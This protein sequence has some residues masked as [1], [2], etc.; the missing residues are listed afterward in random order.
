M[1]ETT[2]KVRRAL[3]NGTLEAILA[4]PSQESVPDLLQAMITLS[5]RPAQPAPVSTTIPF[6]I[7]LKENL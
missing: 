6:R 7:L 5:L 3:A 4:H 1:I 2:P